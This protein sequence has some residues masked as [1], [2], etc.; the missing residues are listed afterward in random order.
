MHLLHTSDWHLGQNF[1]GKSRQAEH[2]ALIDWLLARV[3][4]HA[5]DAVLIA[6]DLF[7]TGTPPS[8]ARELYNKLVLRLDAVQVP[9]VLLGGNHDAVATLEESCDLF[10]RL[11]TRVV[12]RA[13]AP[14]KHVHVLKDRSGEEAC[15]LGALPFL[16]PRDLI[17]SQGGQSAADKEQAL[18]NAIRTHYG[19]VYAALLAAQENREKTQGRRLPIVMTGHLTTVGA[20]MSDSV[21]D[22]YV[23]SLAAFSAQAFPPADYIALGHIHR[24]QRVAP[25]IRYSG[26]PLAL[27]F[28]ESRQQKE[29]LMVE[30]DADGLREI[31]P[32]PV[33]Y[34]QPLFSLRGRLDELAAAIGAAAAH[35]SSERPAWLEITVEGEDYLADLPSRLADLTAGW[36]LEI[37]CIRRARSRQAQALAPIRQERLDELTPAEVFARRLA[38]ENLDDALSAELQARYRATLAEIEYGIAENGEAGA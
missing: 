11:G 3:D 32:L 8:Y 12:A 33:P 18:Q 15:L 36:P 6:G 7:D 26:S 28:D 13:L 29:M 27:G 38:A 24:P 10:A 23:G 37:L 30:L 31:T 20:Q 17:G 16:R 25:H 2:L 21:R 4:E 9:L 22:I 35:G 5:I 19:A 34:F 1:M 14:E